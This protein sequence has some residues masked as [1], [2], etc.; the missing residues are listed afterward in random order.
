MDK[1]KV[2]YKKTVLY[3][4]GV[5]YFIGD[6]M[7]VALTSVNPTVA[8][9]VNKL[10]EFKLANKAAILSGLI[11]PVDEP[12]IE[13]ET[14]NTFSDEELEVLTKNYLALKSKLQKVDSLPTLYRILET[15]KNNDRSRK[16]LTLI[17]A[18]IEEID[19]PEDKFSVHPDDMQGV[20]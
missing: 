2:Y 17:E 15:A 9:D 7:G 1:E 12:S 10:R 11:M 14:E 5:R 3:T 18:R 16:T 20:E 6:A 19:D 13:W 4:V 8:V